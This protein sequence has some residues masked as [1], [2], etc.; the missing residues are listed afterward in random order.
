MY[1]LKITKILREAGIPTTYHFDG[2]TSKQLKKTSR[3]AAAAIIIGENEINSNKIS[4][5]NLNTGQQTMVSL[6]DLPNYCKNIQ[7]SHVNTQ[8]KIY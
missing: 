3:D 8:K 4:V 5:K 2:N 6:E 1:A 7:E